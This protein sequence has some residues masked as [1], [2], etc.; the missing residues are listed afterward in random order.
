MKATK[1]NSL[2][3]A[4]TLLTS[5]LSSAAFAQ[6]TD[7][8]A[9]VIRPD[10]VVV[11]KVL[12]GYERG[13]GGSYGENHPNKVLI[14]H[15]TSAVDNNGYVYISVA[16]QAAAAHEAHK[17]QQGNREGRGQGKKERDE[18]QLGQGCATGES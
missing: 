3:L 9:P 15:A 13:N 5:A 10:Q 8:N 1:A 17:H 14:C 2:I 4:A 11:K 6:S 7:P 12:P 16:G 18:I